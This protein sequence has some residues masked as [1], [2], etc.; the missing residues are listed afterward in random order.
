MANALRDEIKKKL[1]S[2]FEFEGLVK[3]FKNRTTNQYAKH[4]EPQERTNSAELN[5]PVSLSDED[6]L[7]NRNNQSLLSIS[8]LE[9][10]SKV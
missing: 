9:S 4:Q 7:K 6:S 3:N 8:S 5:K 1:S 2:V 10:Q